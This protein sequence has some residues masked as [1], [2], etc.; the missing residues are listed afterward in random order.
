MAYSYSMD[1]GVNGWAFKLG[2][3][4]YIATS[5]RIRR[6]SPSPAR[7]VGEPRVIPHHS[8]DRRRSAARCARL[9]P[10]G[11]DRFTSR[12]LEAAALF[13]HTAAAAWR[14]A[15]LYRELSERAISDPLTG[16]LNSRWL[17]EVGRARAGAESCA[18]GQSLAIL[19][20]D[21]DRFKQINDSG[22]HSAGDLVLRRVGAALQGMIRSGDAAVRLGG[23]EFLLAASR[24]RRGRRRTHRDRIARSAGGP[25]AAAEL[26]AAGQAHRF[27]GHCGPAAQRHRPRGAGSRRR[28]RHVRGETRRWRSL[29]AERAPAG[30]AGDGAIQDEHPGSRLIRDRWTDEFDPPAKS[31]EMNNERATQTRDTEGG[32]L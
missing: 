17:R 6:R 28:C 25:S 23:E 3:P 22:G 1:L 4:Q 18:V 11:I 26:P 9:Q 8:A 24:R 2:I 20:L 29:S 16:L 15:E 32:A 19:L 21:L 30:R 13:G 12:D 14:N 31:V 10:P 27:D 7:P 5:L